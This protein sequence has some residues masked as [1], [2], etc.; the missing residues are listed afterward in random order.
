MPT[1]RSDGVDIRYETTG[2]GPAVLFL[3][4]VG[5]GAWLWGWQ[6]AALAGP[7]ETLTVDPRGTGDSDAPPGP[8]DVATLAA[9]VEAVLRDHGVSRVHLVG[10]GLGGMVALAY[11]REYGR[12]RSLVLL[13]TALSGEAVDEG[14]LDVMA[15][16]GPDSLAPCFSESFFETQRE[17]VAGIEKWREDDDA[18]SEGRAAQAAAMLEFA[19]DAPYEV[20]L[21]ALVCHGADDPVVPVT[22]GRE[23]AD[24][25]PQG[26]FTE[27]PGRHLAFVESSRVANDAIAGFLE[28]VT[29]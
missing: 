26:T 21:P 7:F 19:C 25:L 20:T 8:Y 3:N 5:Y 22:A 15:G 16:R 1:A 29:E 2:D 10:A 6:H 18:R 24:A 12:A 23:L 14:M 27:V 13:D 4:D 11:A 17:V 28:R 9:D